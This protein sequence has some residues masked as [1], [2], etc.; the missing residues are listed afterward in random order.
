MADNIIIAK[1]LT[2]QYKDTTAVDNISF[3][4]AEGSLFAFLGPNGA[5]K[6]TTIKMLTTLITPTSGK[7]TLNGFDVAKD[8][9]DVRRSFGIVFQDPSLD[10]ELTAYENMQ[11]HAVFY[12]LSRKEYDPRIK[13]LLELVELTDRQTH[14]VK[15]FSGG[16]KRRLEIA[17]GLLHHPRILFLDEPTLGLDT[18]TRH[19]L[20]E[21]VQRLNKKEN[22]TIFFSTHYLEEAEEVAEQIAIIDHGK[23]VARGTSKELEKQTKTNSLEEAYLSLTGKEVRDEEVDSKAAMRMRHRARGS[24]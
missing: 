2:K 15:T 16:M 6:S 13:E 22:M 14:Q 20:W 19:L 17:R 7:L 1:N 11:L 23:I 12:G 5:G 8:Q 4:V 24:R 18:Q 3:E 9:I 21:Y 10:D